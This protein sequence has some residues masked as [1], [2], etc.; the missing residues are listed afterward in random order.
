MRKILI[1]EDDK[2]ISAV[3][4]LFLKNLG[5]EIVGSCKNGSEALIEC[6]R[7]KPDIVLMDI[8]LEGDLDGIQ[9]AERLRREC[10]IPI[11]FVSGDTSSEVVER[12]V[13]SNSYGYLVKPV[14][15]KELGITIE[16]AYYKHK[17]DVEQKLREQS[18]RSFV[19]EAPTP[20]MIVQDGTI[21][22]LNRLSLDLFK[23]HYMEDLV[24]LALSDFVGEKFQSILNRV[25][26]NSEE[27]EMAPTRL[28]IKTLHKKEVEVMVY[29]SRTR[30]NNRHALQLAFVEMSEQLGWRNSL[31]KW[32]DAALRGSGPLLLLSRKFEVVDY[33]RGFEKVA[34]PASDF[35]GQP[36]SSLSHWLCL[37][38]EQVAN[39]L[40]VE[41]GRP[42]DLDVEVS[43]QKLACQGYPLL[44]AKGE[45]EQILVS[46]K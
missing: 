10:E 30:F 23:T 7:K 9:T 29:F 18:F 19:S 8:H 42:F 43:S 13:I 21:R 34:K 37:N 46:V 5:Y 15:E 17:S 6:E 11:I 35:R 14:N 28:V 39:C 45:V 1:V 20:I 33:N 22:Y 16:L 2:F 32:R 41:K 44:N 26:D 3:Y 25:L 31:N 40:S 36:I 4:S 12:A 27:K 38:E 24:G